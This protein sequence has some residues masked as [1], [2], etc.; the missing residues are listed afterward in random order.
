M[1]LGQR[2]SPK[3]PGACPELWERWGR[4]SHCSKDP[5]WRNVP[6]GSWLSTSWVAHVECLPLRTQHP[7]N[8]APAASLGRKGWC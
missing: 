6:G 3:D 5:V 1:H 4:T 8:S 7:G 2:L